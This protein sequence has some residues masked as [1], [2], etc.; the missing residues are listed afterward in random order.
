[1]IRFFTG[2]FSGL[3]VGMVTHLA[4]AS[5]LMA[6]YFGL[7]TALGVWFADRVLTGKAP[8]R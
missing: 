6:L 5:T 7:A 3:A 8:R 2:L 1:V 4:N